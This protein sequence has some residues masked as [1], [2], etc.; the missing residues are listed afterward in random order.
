M[1]NYEE[2]KEEGGGEE[3]GFYF[4]SVGVARPTCPGYSSR[5]SYQ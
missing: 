4:D 2:E 5:R 1:K 3:K